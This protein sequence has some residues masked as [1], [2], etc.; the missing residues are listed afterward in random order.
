MKNQHWPHRFYSDSDSDSDSDNDSDNYAGEYKGYYQGVRGEEGF[1][2]QP[3]V[4]PCDT[5]TETD[6]DIG[7]F[8]IISRG[9][10]R[11]QIGKTCIC[12]MKKFTKNMFF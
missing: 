3:L 12:S 1:L 4:A 9:R 7:I 10:S 2:I 8:P 6:T 11:Y 5:D